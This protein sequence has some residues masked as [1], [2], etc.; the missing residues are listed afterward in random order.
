MT[1]AEA[2][3]IAILIV[4]A[5]IRPRKEAPMTINDNMPDP[6]SAQIAGDKLGAIGLMMMCLGDY[7]DATLTPPEL[8]ALGMII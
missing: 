7:V 5:R 1:P 8:K 4:G 2:K 3:A 6:A